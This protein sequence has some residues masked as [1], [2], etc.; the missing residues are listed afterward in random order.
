[1]FQPPV[2]V[3]SCIW[4]KHTWQCTSE[5]LLTREV[6]FNVK[7]Y[8]PVAFGQIAFTNSDVHKTPEHDTVI[9]IVIIGA[10]VLTCAYGTNDSFMEM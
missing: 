4:L 10:R 6:F 8:R 5:R 1:M 2:I 3:F 9:K 7:G